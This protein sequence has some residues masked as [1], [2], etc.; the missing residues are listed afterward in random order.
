[1]K[2]RCLFIVFLFVFALSSG[3]AQIPPDRYNTQKGAAI[4]AGAGALIGQAIGGNTEGTLIGLAAGTILGALVGNAVD[5]D[6]QAVRDAVQ[7][8]KQVIYYDRQGSAV[9][10]IPHNDKV[11]TNCRK[12]TKRVWKDGKLVSE[13]VE[14]ICEDPVV[15]YRSRPPVVYPYYPA[16]SFYYH[17]YPGYHKYWPHPYHPRH[18]RP[19]YRYWR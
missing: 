18:H 3:C 16:F 4:G 8:E 1:M 2:S 5:Q 9:E 12:V 17:S 15:Y 11:K 6:Y 10:V 7:N 19:Y 14:E 13:T